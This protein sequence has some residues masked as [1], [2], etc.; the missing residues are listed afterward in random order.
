MVARKIGQSRTVLV[1][2]LAFGVW[3]GAAS[4]AG[5]WYLVMP[6]F[7]LEQTRPVLVGA[8]LFEAALRDW[9]QLRAFD[10]ATA[11]EHAKREEWEKQRE[12][13]LSAKDQQPRTAAL[14]H[15]TESTLARLDALGASQCIASD[16]PR[17]K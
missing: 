7:K 5:G 17:L 13:W 8:Y 2:V 6:P 4:G 15:L 14:E 10:T 11:C 12:V 3:P 9:E 1:L 16:D